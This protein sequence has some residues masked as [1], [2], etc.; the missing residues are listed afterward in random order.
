M[1]IETFPLPGEKFFSRCNNFSYVTV[2]SV[3]TM[4]NGT[5][6]VVFEDPADGEPGVLTVGDFDRYYTNNAP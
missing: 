4:D 6:W 1:R 3:V 2:L 5:V